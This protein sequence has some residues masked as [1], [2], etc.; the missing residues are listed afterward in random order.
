MVEKDTQLKKNK[1][2]IK[3]ITVVFFQSILNNN[4]NKAKIIDIARPRKINIKI[5][6]SISSIFIIIYFY[7]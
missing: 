2:K 5:L 1:A 4:I 6:D 3:E 7:I